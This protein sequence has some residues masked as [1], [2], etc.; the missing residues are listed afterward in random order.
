MIAPKRGGATLNRHRSEQ[1][2]ETP[3]DFLGAVVRRFGALAVDLAATPQ[4]RKAPAAYSPLADSL[5]HDW[6]PHEGNLWLNPPFANIAPWAAKCRTSAAAPHDF[7]RILLLVPASVGSR[8]Y[9]DH[10]HG[11]AMVLALTGRLTFVGHRSPY[12]KDL[13]L[14]VYGEWRGFDCWDWRRDAAAVVG[15]VWP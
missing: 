15:Q 6:T 14:A 10:V 13:I 9:A 3:A 11:H 1:D 8:W 2:V 7:D 12:P 5:S 4:N